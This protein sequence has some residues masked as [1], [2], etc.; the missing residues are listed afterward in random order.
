AQAPTGPLPDQGNGDWEN[1][2]NDPGGTKFSTLAQ[3]TPENVGKL[4]QAWVYRVGMLPKYD[5]DLE[6]TPLKVGRTVYLCNAKNDIFALDAETGALRWKFDAGVNY[7]VSARHCRGVA[8][9][10]APGVTGHCAERIITATLDARLM[11]VDAQDGQRC[12]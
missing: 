10:K 11:A 3:I 12:Q 6:V 1:Y 5:G 2:G 8:Y 4:E 7:Q 9:Y